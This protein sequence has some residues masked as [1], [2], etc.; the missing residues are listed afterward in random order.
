MKIE[1]LFTVLILLC[2]F[3]SLKNIGLEDT[4]VGLLIADCW[5]RRIAGGFLRALDGLPVIP[6]RKKRK[7]TL[8]TERNDTEMHI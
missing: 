1:K 8:K 3:L 4:A 2:L 7:F 5:C 6:A